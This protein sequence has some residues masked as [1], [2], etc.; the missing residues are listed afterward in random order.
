M[1]KRTSY[2]IVPF[3]ATLSSYANAADGTINF[4]GEI[5]ETACSV[6]IGA[7][8][9]LNVILGK[10]AKSSF[11][12]AG[13]TAAATKFTIKLRNCPQSLSSATIKFDGKMN[14]TNNS[15]LALT[16]GT[17]VAEGI[18]VALY[19][20]SQSLVPLMTSS[21][22]YNLS[23]ESENNLEFYAKYIATS[24]VEAIKAGTANAT[25]TFSVIYN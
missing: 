3:I 11:Q 22:N 9:S 16:S 14:S 24:A 10:V 25:T 8:N 15:Y 7:N 21:T 17:G 12:S 2:F 18:A 4:T 23:S 13:E 1:M 6:N 5:L 19:D 20:S